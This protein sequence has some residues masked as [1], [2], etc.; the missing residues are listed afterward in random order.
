MRYSLSQLFLIALIS[1]FSVINDIP[2]DIIVTSKHHCKKSEIKRRK[3]PIIYC[4][5]SVASYQASAYEKQ[6]RV[7]IAHLVTKFGGYRHV[8]SRMPS[9]K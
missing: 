8:K 4:A 5:N 1:I 9:T 3:C 7:T 6:G 2:Q